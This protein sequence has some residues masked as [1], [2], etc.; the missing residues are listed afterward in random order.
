MWDRAVRAVLTTRGGASP[1]LMPCQGPGRSS[2]RAEQRIR[3]AWS[4]E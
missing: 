4:V 3:T 2:E 1:V